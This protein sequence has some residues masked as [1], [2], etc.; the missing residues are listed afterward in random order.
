MSAENGKSMEVKKFFMAFNQI[1]YVTLKGSFFSAIFAPFK[2]QWEVH[3]FI[4][5]RKRP[6]LFYVH[7]LQKFFPHSLCMKYDYPNLQLWRRGRG[8][9][10][11]SKKSTFFFCPWLLMCQFSTNKISSDKLRNVSNFKTPQFCFI[12]F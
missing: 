4:D 1:F 3:F 12:V 9:P 2:V 6:L 11:N 10:P 7:C 5:C 8:G